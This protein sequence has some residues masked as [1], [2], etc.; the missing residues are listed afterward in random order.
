MKLQRE[1]EEMAQKEQAEFLQKQRKIEEAQMQN[2]KLFQDAI[3]RT[4]EEKKKVQK[5]HT[6]QIHS[7]KAGFIQD[8]DYNQIENMLVRNAHNELRNDFTISMERIKQEFEMTNNQMKKQ[9]E[10]LKKATDKEKEEKK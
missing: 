4:K 6:P 7:T 2:E 8:T 9:I 5:F 3:I 1:R 10:L